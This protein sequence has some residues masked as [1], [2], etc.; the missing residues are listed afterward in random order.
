MLDM[1]P[2]IGPP[3]PSARPAPPPPPPDPGRRRRRG[4]AAQRTGRAA[5]DLVLRRYLARGWRVAAR[6]WRAGRAHGGGEIDLILRRPGL[7]LFV[8]VKARRTL[9]EAAWALTPAQY[10]RMEAAVLRWMALH[11]APEE[12]LRL[13]LALVD[14]AG[15][16]EIREN[17]FA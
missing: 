9:E 13:D 6:N 16:V 2:D 7:W 12:D 5:E 10:G 11:G 14:R 8:E 1:L 17:A 4:R 3:A 15:W